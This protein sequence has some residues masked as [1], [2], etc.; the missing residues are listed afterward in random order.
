MGKKISY[1]DN[2]SKSKFNTFKE[3]HTSLDNLKFI[4]KKGFLKSYDIIDQALK[5]CEYNKV[6]KCFFWFFINV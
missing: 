4:S 1:Y 6:Y 3:Y 5:I 2:F